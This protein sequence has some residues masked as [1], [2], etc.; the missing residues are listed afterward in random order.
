LCAID[1]DF[2]DAQERKFLPVT[3]LA[4]RILAPAFFENNDLGSAALFHHLG[5]YRSAGDRRRAKADVIAAKE[6]D[7]LQLN[8]LAGLSFDLV[9]PDDIV[10]GNP[11]LLA[12]G[13]DDCEHLLP[14]VRC[15]VSGEVRT[16]F[17]QSLYRL[18]L[19][20]RSLRPCWVMTAA[21]L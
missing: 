12:A 10:C 16:G 1:E 20:A 11:V 7:L 14:R 2:S 15:R 13:L 18:L 6:E 19:Q 8:D 3:A 5:S 4:T 21:Y 9:N 17:F